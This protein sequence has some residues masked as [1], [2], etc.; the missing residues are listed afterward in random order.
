MLLLFD[1]NKV[2]MAKKPEKK[3]KKNTKWQECKHQYLM[4]AE[5]WLSENKRE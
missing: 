4:V 2:K 5:Y 3:Q 1:D